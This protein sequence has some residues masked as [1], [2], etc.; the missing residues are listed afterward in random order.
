MKIENFR[1]TKNHDLLRVAATV[2]WENCGRPTQEI[3]FETTAQFA[4]SLTCDPH[5]FLIASIIPA[6]HYGE[7]RIYLDAE[8]CP[9]LRTGLIEAMKWLQQWYKGDRTLVSIE[10]KTKFNFAA[11]EF[12]R[13]AF[14][15]SG[16]IDSLATLRVNRL[17]FPLEH[18]RSFKD[19]ILILGLEGHE[20]E[21]QLTG[22]HLNLLSQLA[23]AADINLV[24][25]YTNIR[26]LNRDL[27]FW[28]NEFQSAVLSAV[29]HA[30]ST[31]FTDV[32]IASSEYAPFLVPYATHPLLDLNYSSQNLQIRHD[33]VLLSRLDKTKIVAEWNVGLQNLK[34]CTRNQYE[35]LNC[36]RCEK[37]LRTM[38]ALEAVGMLE[39]TKVFLRK[40]L[41]EEVLVNGA[42]IGDEGIKYCYLE[43]VDLLKKRGREDLVR[44]IN[45]I[46]ARFDEKDVRGMI[47]RLDR[48]LFKGHLVDSAKK[49]KHSLKST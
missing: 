22:Q 19:G 2:I 42:Y 26:D 17:N 8:I 16:G 31:R 1:T 18:P 13:A 46:V 7:K 33:S 32:T 6:M 41:S 12:Q 44:G 30:F 36:G 5:A 39:K 43:T 24:P 35:D 34:V 48:Q 47:Q 38:T 15:F 20:V 9:E 10:A 23:I 29:A 4:D 27:E 40:D 21:D 3:Y 49:I 11:F 37:C 28:H 14:F 45:R 25:V